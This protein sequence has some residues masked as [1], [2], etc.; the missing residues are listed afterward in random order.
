[1]E[2]LKIAVWLR[3]SQLGCKLRKFLPAIPLGTN[4]RKIQYLD[5]FMKYAF[6]ISAV[7]VNNFDTKY[8]F[9]KSF[10]PNVSHQAPM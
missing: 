1:M 5:T 6:K 3:S 9:I 4:T 10:L 7:L 8:I 2:I